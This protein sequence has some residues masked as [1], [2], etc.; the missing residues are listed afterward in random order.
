[1]P[2]VLNKLQEMIQDKGEDKQL[3]ALAET[4]ETQYKQ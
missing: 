1:V 4:A 3:D 2:K